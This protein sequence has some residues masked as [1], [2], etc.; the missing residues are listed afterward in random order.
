MDENNTRTIVTAQVI[1]FVALVLMEEPTS[2]PLCNNINANTL[3][4]C[5]PAVTGN[6]L[7]I[8]NVSASSNLI[9]PF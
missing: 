5:R 2:I 7:L 9:S 8:S 3:E 6:K 4:K 1:V